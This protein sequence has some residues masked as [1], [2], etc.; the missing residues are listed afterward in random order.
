MSFD[1]QKHKTSS[2]SKRQFLALIEKNLN[3]GVDSHSIIQDMISRGHDPAYTQQSVHLVLKSQKNKFLRISG[4]SAGFF[5]LGMILTLATLES[6]S[7]YIWFGAI[8]FGLGG[9]FYGLNKYRKL[10]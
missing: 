10:K 6:G 8:L 9:I 7:G 2:L 5:L 3:E 1:P 4:I